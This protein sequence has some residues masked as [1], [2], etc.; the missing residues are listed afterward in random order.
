MNNRDVIGADEIV[1]TSTSS[2]IDGRVATY[3]DLLVED[4]ALHADEFWLVEQSTGV[5]YV[6]RHE[7]GIYYAA[8]GVWHYVPDLDQSLL[9]TTSPVF[10]GL[11][12]KDQ[13]TAQRYRQVI[14]DGA[15]CIQKES[16]PN[17]WI[18]KYKIGD[19]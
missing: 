17:V 5:W 11:I 13:V 15:Y 9:T 1:A 18:T 19:Q 7:R 10:A 4:A 14:I 8:G 2:F 6:N 16:A 12:L 3:A